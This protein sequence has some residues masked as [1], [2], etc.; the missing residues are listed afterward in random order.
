MT[1]HSK[2]RQHGHLE[3][4]LLP[5]ERLMDTQTR[6]IASESSDA[7]VILGFN[8]RL[9][10][11]TEYLQMKWQVRICAEITMGWFICNIKQIALWQ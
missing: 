9:S 11:K 10:D 8:N 1:V 2:H 4:Y 5:H 7:T 6:G 3:P